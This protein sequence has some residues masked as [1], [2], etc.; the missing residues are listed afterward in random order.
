[1]ELSKYFNEIIKKNEKTQENRITFNDMVIF[2][3]KI[4]KEYLFINLKWIDEEIAK[5]F[6]PQSGE[7]FNPFWIFLIINMSFIYFINY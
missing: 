4:I 6:T 1:M 7:V 2:D 5:M 3:K